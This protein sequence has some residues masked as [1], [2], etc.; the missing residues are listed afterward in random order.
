MHLSP[1]PPVC[2]VRY[3]SRTMS[4]TSPCATS[5]FRL[6]LGP[7]PPRPGTPGPVRRTS[8]PQASPQGRRSRGRLRPERRRPWWRSPRPRAPPLNARRRTHPPRGCRTAGLRRRASNRAAPTAG[9]TS[10]RA[11]SDGRPRSTPTPGAAAREAG[12]PGSRPSAARCR[13]R[14]R[15]RC[16]PLRPG[17]AP[18]P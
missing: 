13:V 4:R 14:I 11:P 5:A 7:S 17:R 18:R 9:A 2:T 10:R 6:R 8:H 3:S 15:P 16:H 12:D 1:E